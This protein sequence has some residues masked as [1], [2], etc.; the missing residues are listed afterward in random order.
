[1]H[2]HEKIGGITSNSS[3]IQDFAEFIDDCNLMELESFR[4]PYTWF[5]KIR[6]SSSIFKKLDRVPTNDQWTLYFRYASVEN[7]PINGSNHGPIVLHLDKQM[8]EIKSRTFRCEEF[9][10]HIPGFIDVVKGSWNTIFVGSNAFQ[11]IKIIQVF[12]QTVKTWNKRQVG[13]LEENLKQ[14]EK[15]ID[16]GARDFN[17]KSTQCFPPG[18][19]CYNVYLTQK[20]NQV[21]KL[22]EIKWAHKSRQS[23][24]QLGDKY[25]RYFQ[26][27]AL[28]RRRKNKI[29]KIRDA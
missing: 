7:L 28:N 15:E 19:Q 16:M 27:L 10:F 5:K 26:T 9:W 18:K 20:L 17:V 11:L 1:M 22:K 23:W 21:L 13:K 4:L 3:R 2:P 8:V 24:T 14:I 12:R 25:N 6:E 29:W